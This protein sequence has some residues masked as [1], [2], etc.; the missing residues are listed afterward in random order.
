MIKIN[1]KRI[2]WAIPGLLLGAV[3]GYA[4]WFYVGCNSG[5]C[6]I[7]SD[8]L[9]STIYGTAMGFFLSGVVNDWTNEREKNKNKI[10]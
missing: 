8:P 4:Y 2:L 1:R 9:N 7:T 6:L 3:G 10:S 5:S